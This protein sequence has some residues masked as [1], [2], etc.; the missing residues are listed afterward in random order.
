[1]P[2]P[3]RPDVDSNTLRNRLAALRRRLR[4]VHTVRGVGLLVGCVVALIALAGLLDWQIHLPGLVRALLLV[5]TLTGAGYILFRYLL[6]PLSARTDD[7][8]LALRVEECYPTLNDALASTVQFLDQQNHPTTPEAPGGG[9]SAPLRREAVRRTLGMVAGYDFNRVVDSRGLTSAS[10]AL[11]STVVLIAALLVLAPAQAGTALVRF[12]HPFGG[13]EWP[14]QTR[15]EFA[16]SQRF[17][18]GRNEAFEINAL[19]LGVIPEQAVVL[20][21]FEGFPLQENRCAIQKDSEQSGKLSIRLEPG[22]IQRSFHFRILANDAE[23]PEKEV[24]VLP[25]PDLAPLEGQPSPQLQVLPPGYTGLPS[26]EVLPPGTGNLDLVAGS[27]V[28]FLAAADRP[29]RRAWIEYQP[30]L[31][32]AP[33]TLF[34]GPLGANTPLEAAALAAGGQTVWDR[35]PAVLDETGKTLTIRFMPR[36]AGLYQLHL[37]DPIGLTS[38]RLF[39]LRLHADPA[40]TVR[41]ERPSPTKDIL[42]VLPAAKLNLQ[43]VA[44]DPQFALRTVF[45]RYRTNRE[46]A[47]RQLTLY[48]PATAPGRLLAPWSGVSVLGWSSLRLRIPHLEVEQKLPIQNFRHLNGLPLK[49]GDVLILQACADDFDDVTVNKQPGC[50]HEVEIHIVGSNALDLILNQ[51]QALIQQELLKLREKERE[52]IEKVREVEKRV[53]RGDRLSQEEL[54]QLLQAEQIQQQIH[55]RIGNEHKGLRSDL[56]RIQET[57]KQNGMENSPIRDRMADVARELERLAEKE[58]PR[59]EARLTEAREQSEKRSQRDEKAADSERQAQEAQKAAQDKDQQASEAARQ[60][61][62]AAGAEKARL[63]EEARRLKQQSLE[64]SKKAARLQEEAKIERQ[65]AN[66]VTPREQLTDARQH[67]EEVEK[68]LNDLLARLEPWSSAQEVKGEAKRLLEDQKQ[69]QRQ[70]EDQ[71]NK[72][73]QGKDPEK[74]TEQ[75][76]NDLKNM[77]EAQQRL[78]ERT[79]QLLNKMQRM[80]DQRAD[81]DPETAR[82][83]REA[84]KQ[85]QQED[86]PGKMKKA[87]EQIGNNE[88]NQAQQNQK[89]SIAGLQK[90][91][92]NLDDRREAELDRLAKKLKDAEKKLDELTDEQERLQKKA[93]ETG[94]I[95]DPVQRE[96]ALKRLA[97]EQQQLEQKAQDLVKQLSRLR[98]ERASQSLGKA[99]GEMG[100]AGQQLQRGQKPEEQQ[101]DALDRLDEARREIEQARKQVE[102]EL[103][104]EQLTRVADTIKRLKERQ[105][106]L[107]TDMLQKQN[108]V[109]QRKEWTRGLRLSMLS[110][111]E[112]QEGLKGEVEDT[113]GKELPGTP[114]FARM[115]QRSAE[116]MNDAGKRIKE[117]SKAPPKLETL[118]DQETR[119]LQQLALRRLEQVLEVIQSEAQRPAG[120]QAGGGPGGGGEGNGGAGGQQGLPPLAQLRLLRALQQDVNQRTETFKKDHADLAKLTEKEKA[121]LDSIR[122]EQADVAELLEDLT[123]PADEPGNPEGEKKP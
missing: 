65:E 36:L 108:D 70:T 40:P 116:A 25:P 86:I 16:Q 69:L 5:G 121:E 37:E 21:R 14:R 52:A 22:R 111:G 90:L 109:L 17:Q 77:K 38:Q 46:E 120:A 23:T 72:P 50:S 98:A 4:L 43:I 11:V 13:H 54:S 28:L 80:S 30:E 24:K 59:V 104:R 73:T 60:A 33:L 123:K 102:D 56:A 55:E 74:L 117:M 112:A 96:E 12:L 100:Q 34:L 57:L 41:L 62:K 15:I 53:K 76:K 3:A 83:L 110:L 91:V 47:P 26:P 101:E 29:L 79:N 27:A 114:V 85:A 82:E 87:R 105:E 89:E 88:L 97:R 119:R 92:K 99:G 8:S 1:M 122:K 66:K 48:D 45:L 49:E 42:S 32:Q 6:E 113:A 67:Q 44:D 95:A 10:G 64:E 84:H 58:L 7:L 9:D 61:E 81:K 63:Q 35:V 18:V 93:K 71:A 39:E 31:A 20:V 19:V 2:A 115:L 106:S 118:P 75:E 51:E 107:N 68:T 78:E 103:T 94:Q